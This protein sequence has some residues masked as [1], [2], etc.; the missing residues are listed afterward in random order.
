MTPATTTPGRWTPATRQTARLLRLIAHLLHARLQ[1]LRGR[2]GRRERSR[3]W[4]VQLLKILNVRMV[5]SG[6]VPRGSEPALIVANHT[7]WL[8]IHVLAAVTGARFVAPAEV[9]HVPVIGA[10]AAAA[11]IF[12][13]SRNSRRD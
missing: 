3:L 1:A 9:R 13:V 10:I 2:A 8:D 4:A 12:P 6:T 5:V 11:G 7:S